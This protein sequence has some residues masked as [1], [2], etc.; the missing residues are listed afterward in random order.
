MEERIPTLQFSNDN[1]RIADNDPIKGAEQ[2]DT[3]DDNGHGH[4]IHDFIDQVNKLTAGKYKVVN[5]IIIPIK[6]EKR[7]NNEN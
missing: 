1:D 7:E 3:S 6:E 5:G 2:V 4:S